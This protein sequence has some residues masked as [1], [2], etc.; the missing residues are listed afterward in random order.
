MNVVVGRMNGVTALTEV[1]YKIIKSVLP[2]QKEM[3]L[4]IN[5]PY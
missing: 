4:T 2:R 3:A 1:S 5:W